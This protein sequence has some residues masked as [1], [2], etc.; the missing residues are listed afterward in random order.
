MFAFVF[1]SVLFVQLRFI[2]DNF[3]DEFQFK[4]C[5]GLCLVASFDRWVIDEK[6]QNKTKN[7][8]QLHLLSNAILLWAMSI[9]TS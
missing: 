8:I 9:A 2:W 1:V 4:I 7:S 3:S 6:K 5:F